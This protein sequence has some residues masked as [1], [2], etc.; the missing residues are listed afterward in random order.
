MWQLLELGKYIRGWTTRKAAPKH[1]QT[2]KTT[3]QKTFN[4]W[5]K[6]IAYGEQIN[7]P[8]SKG[9]K[10]FLFHS[11]SYFKTPKKKLKK[12]A[13]PSVT[14]SSEDQNTDDE[15]FLDDGD[16]T[17][18]EAFINDDHVDNQYSTASSFEVYSRLEGI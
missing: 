4:Q 5:T 16:S 17:D 10:S 1:K 3:V 2:P 13:S 18:D 8:S 11:N 15:R 7:D 12:K 14:E 6:A 9:W